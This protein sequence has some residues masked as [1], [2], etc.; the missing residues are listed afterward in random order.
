[1]GKHVGRALFVSS[2]T[3]S[4]TLPL[5]G[6]SLRPVAGEGLTMYTC[7]HTD[8]HTH[9]HTHTHAHTNTNTH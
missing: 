3:Y 2:A 4:P 6:P 5:R 7:T 1:M 8:T 9:T